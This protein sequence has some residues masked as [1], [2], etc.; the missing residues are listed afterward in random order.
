MAGTARYSELE[1]SLHLLRW[2]AV[3][4]QLLAVWAATAVLGL[5][6]ELPAL[7][8]GICALGL[9]NALLGLWR[10]R[11]PGTETA[12]LLG[13][14]VDLAALTWALY[15][16]GGAMNPFSQLYLVPVALTAAVL[17]ASRVI[18]LA[19]ASAAAYVFLA[20]EAPGLRFHHLGS[21]F[22]LH[23]AGMAVNFAL[24]LLLFCGFG[25]RLAAR[26]RRQSQ[27]LAEARERGLR[28]EGLHA[29]ALQ[30]AST[31]HEV[32]TPLATARLL[33]DEWR[34]SPGSPPPAEDLDLMARQLDYARDA[35]RRLVRDSH[36]TAG[37]QTLAE[38]V[39]DLA[40]RL[41]LLRPE[42]G[43]AIHLPPALETRR[44]CFPPGLKAALGHLL[45]N[46]ADA[47]RRS[48]RTD[49]ELT[50]GDAGTALTIEIRDHGPGF[51]AEG[52][53]P[54]PP[55]QPQ[56]LGLGLQLAN[57]TLETLGGHLE[58]RPAE[59]GGLCTRVCL[60]WSAIVAG[61]PP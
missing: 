16:T 8:L 58:H 35:V 33:L 2:L 14:G 34:A 25:L 57:A 36:E 44:V 50:L 24:A 11:R 51:V 29:L 22:D 1:G 9:A 38:A 39:R 45:D 53:E 6:L 31:A 60:P 52:P 40:G 26:L 15:F 20:L 21:A 48:S 17:P 46:A 49:V 55:G 37:P 3:G 59:G 42:T 13:L 23:I 41:A 12:L 27:A 10:L 43:L 18:A 54:A 56:G 61:D 28:D 47:G 32:N 30:A 19:L 7:L 5:E 4:G